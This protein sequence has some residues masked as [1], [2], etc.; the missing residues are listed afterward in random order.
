MTYDLAQLSFLLPWPSNLRVHSHQV[1]I[2][3]IP[4]VALVFLQTPKYATVRNVSEMDR[5]ISLRRGRGGE[6][7]IKEFLTGASIH[8]FN[9]CANAAHPSALYPDDAQQ[10][11]K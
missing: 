11:I 1:I 5:D 7:V 8:C 10:S 3:G 9:C 2:D 4:L 6:K